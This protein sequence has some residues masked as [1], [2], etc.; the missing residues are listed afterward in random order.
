MERPIIFSGPM[1]RAILDGR[2]SQTRRVLRPQPV[3]DYGEGGPEGLWWRDLYGAPP[4]LIPGCPYGTPGDRLWCREGFALDDEQCE[5][6]HEVIIY[7]ADGQVRLYDPPGCSGVPMGG[8]PR[9]GQVMPLRIAK[10]APGLRWRPSIHMPRWASRLTLEV[11]G[12]RVERVQEISL[13]DIYA[14]GLEPGPYGAAND[15]VRFGDLW[16]SINERRGAGWEVNPWV[17]VVEFRRVS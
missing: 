7:R 10:D 6:S 15:V 4:E 9:L 17:W 14:E 3:Q 11:T 16:D 8:P 13:E 12:V 2:K 5:P 1:V